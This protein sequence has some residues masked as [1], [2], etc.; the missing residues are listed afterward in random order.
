[1]ITYIFASDPTGLIGVDNNLP[2]HYPEDLKFFK[3]NTVKKNIVM[4]FN[5][6]KSLNYKPLPNRTNIVLVDKYKSCPSTYKD[7]QFLTVEECLSRF[8]D[9]VIIGGKKT[10]DLFPNPDVILHTQV[11]FVA[12]DTQKHNGVYMPLMSMFNNYSLVSTVTKTDLIFKTYVK[13]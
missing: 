9:L 5:T 4:G 11:P 13:K 1:M 7:V 10:F 2:W 3:D 12:Y 6:F 8:Q